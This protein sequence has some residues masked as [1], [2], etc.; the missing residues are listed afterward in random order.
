MNVHLSSKLFDYRLRSNKSN[1]IH[2]TSNLKTARSWGGI[3]YIAGEDTGLVTVA[4]KPAS[5]PIYLFEHIG[6]GLILRATTWSDDNGHYRFDGLNPNR[7]FLVMAT[8]LADGQYEPI[9]YDM[10][11]AY[12]PDYP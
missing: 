12:V 4:G 2:L 6:N 5:R 9:A 10:V 1:K 7:Y 8:D 3:G 11:Q